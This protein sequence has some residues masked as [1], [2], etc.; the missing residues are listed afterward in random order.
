MAKRPRKRRWP[1][2]LGALA[3][4]GLLGGWWLDRQLEPTRLANTVLSRLGAAAGLELG[5]EGVPDYALRP[6]PRL[7][8]PGF[9]ARLPGAAT[10][11]FRAA[12]VEVSL[13]WSTI[14]GGDEVVITR[15]GLD[16][17]QLD[18]EAMLAWLD[19][20]P[21]SDAPFELPTL[22]DGLRV[23]DGMLVANG[24][25]AEALSLELPT[26]HPGEPATLSL[27]TTWRRGDL[28]LPLEATLTAAQAGLASPLRAEAGG[29]LRTPA[30]DLAWALQ[31]QGAFDASGTPLRLLAEQLRFQGESPLPAFEA[32]GEAGL[33]ETLELQA[34]GK[35][36]EW[37][38]DWPALPAPL[39]PALAL[40]FEF[41]YA[42][43]DDFSAPLRL[44]L[45]QGETR[46]EGETALPDLL[47]WLDTP[48]ATPLP[49]LR[50]R[51]DAPLL[52]VEGV[53][54]EGLVIE[55]DEG[56]GTARAR[57]TPAGREAAEG[58]PDGGDG[59]PEGA[60]GASGR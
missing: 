8:L 49:P 53:Q 26:L 15:I 2:I 4:L 48:A 22:S 23:N 45:S 18:L 60:A 31:L 5:F 43:P 46:F 52:V 17:P 35:L 58:D 20:R 3:A 24:W 50:G 42:G 56:N 25:Q 39:D 33:G 41:A 9:H 32:G 47:A 13:P 16:R 30:L 59:L 21:P 19:S 12:R 51:L 36:R 1:W 10:P 28:E 38:A 29:R 14:W 6:E 44:A 34:R 27:S 11:M 40:P 7:L 54:L 37:P 55:L 57:D